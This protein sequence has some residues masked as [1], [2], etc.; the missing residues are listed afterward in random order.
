MRAEEAQQLRQFRS[1]LVEVEAQLRA[2]R[3]A[4][5]AHQDNWMGK[6][7]CMEGS[8]VEPVGEQLSKCP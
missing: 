4:A 7:V 1:R 2:D 8:G 3:E 5:A 6:T